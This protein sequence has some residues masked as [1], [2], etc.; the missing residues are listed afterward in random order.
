MRII[1]QLTKS[2]ISKVVCLIG[3]LI[4]LILL[5]GFLP[6]TGLIY[7]AL[8]DS[9]HAVVFFIFTLILFKVIQHDS[10]KISISISIC[11]STFLLGGVIELIQP[12]FGRHQSHIDL[13]YDS[14]GSF[15]A[16]VFYWRERI[17]KKSIRLILSL[18]CAISLALSLSLPTTKLFIVWQQYQ[19]LPVLMDFD[20]VWEDEIRA[21][22]LS[23]KLHLAS[24]PVGWQNKTKVAEVVFGVG[25]QYPGF[26]T[27]NIYGDW[28][29]YQNLSID[30]YSEETAVV[31]VIV[32]VNDEF[33]NKRFED[34]FNRQLTIKPGLNK[35][36]IKLDDIREAPHLRRMKVD[37]IASMAFFMKGLDE[38]KTLF[39]DNIE[40]Q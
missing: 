26:S 8:Q 30:I 24:S 19:G 34:R 22:N 23:T 40:L 2:E 16:G 3:F 14:I 38:T 9:S 7:P 1:K 4:G 32:R 25:S 5:I 39:F 17:K 31:K 13:L 35:V 18:L 15:A 21:L 10:K 36:L 12:Y 6:D 20:R 11:I 28:S 29:N 37:E 27:P 33:H